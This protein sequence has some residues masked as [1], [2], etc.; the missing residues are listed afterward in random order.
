VKGEMVLELSQ[1]ARNEMSRN[2]NFFHEKMEGMYCNM[3]YAVY[4]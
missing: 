1:R 4:L 3:L 2:R